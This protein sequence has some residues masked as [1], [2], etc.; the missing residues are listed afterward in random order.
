[1]FQPLQIETFNRRFLLVA[2]AVGLLLF[3][4]GRLLQAGG[5]Q[6]PSGISG[7]AAS[8]VQNR[9]KRVEAAQTLFT[10]ASKAY[11]DQSYAEAMDYY[12]AAF[13]TLPD[14]PAMAAQRQIFFSR[15]QS[16]AFR[17]AQTLADDGRWG[18]C[19]QTLDQ[20]VKLADESG[21]PATEVNPE[22]R[23]MLK[24]LREHDD[25][26]NQAISP[27]HI[28]DAAQ[29]N[30]KLII[31]K[32]YRELGDY[33]RAERT[34]NEV[35]RLDPY[36]TAA[37]R[38]M[39]EMEQ[40]RLD[41]YSAAYSHTRAK[42]VAEVAAGWETPIAPL[43]DEIGTDMVGAEVAVGKNVSIEKKLKEIMIPS[44]E[45]QGATLRDVVDYLGQKAQ[46][47]DSS[48]S[49]P[50]KRG[51]NFVIDTG[52]GA[53]DPASSVINIKLANIPLGVA[54]NYAVSQVGLTY[55]VEGV[56]VRILSPTAAASSNLSTR[57][58]REIPP[59]FLS[60]GGE[61]GGAEPTSPANPFDNSSKPEGGVLIKRVTA[62]QFLEG[63]GVK[64][65]AGAS[66]NFIAA[67]NTL[68]VQN[69]GEQLLLID[70][71][72]QSA[73][74]TVTKQVEI[75]IRIVSVGAEDLR[76]VGLDFLLG[77]SNMGSSAR[78]FFGGGVDGNGGL[79]T[80]SLDFP[81][82]GPGGKP[83]GTYPVTGALRTGDIGGGD[84]LDSVIMRNSP[85]PSTAKAPGIL[86][87]AGVFT[88][89]QF[90][91]VLRA[92]DQMKGTDMLTDTHIVVRPGVKAT[93]EQVREFIYPTEYDPPEIPNQFDGVSTG[94]VFPVTPATPTA[95]ETRKLGLT[96]E[97]EPTVA[98]DNKTVSLNVLTDVT[99]FSGFINYGT[100]ITS[101]SSLTGTTT[102]LT[103]NAILMPVFDVIRE[104]ANPV[105]WDGQTVAIGGFHGES[106]T[107]TEDKIPYL[108]D[109]PVLGRAFRSKTN[110]AKKK[111]LTIF[112]SVR[113]I[114]PG[115]NPINRTQEDELPPAVTTR[116]PV[117][118][119]E[120][121][122][123]P[124]PVVQAK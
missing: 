70:N 48:E 66:A 6:T 62:Q 118:R 124:P 50:V 107:A 35:L 61:A 83:V 82:V 99:D 24:E 51:V 20:I 111:A 13:E 9:Q 112:V 40:L 46:E 58:W 17:Y 23:K 122:S 115:G 73:R 44:L 78:A 69:T 81:F 88:D 103:E 3:P 106:I 15:Y 18:E 120:F 97:V 105:V 16:A 26:Y 94:G 49:D 4:S 108:G 8:E 77:Q 11:A 71:I 64:F 53:T 56:A 28:R 76:Q 84:S 63:R 59:G 89:P 30:T 12:K 38:G 95:F 57:V 47:L 33:D 117:P 25:R 67:T 72:V 74:E 19:E 5:V 10:S 86:S 91:M 22:V 119:S 116:A 90:Q 29:V 39:E 41:Y 34:Y 31:A 7:I 2:G 55:R 92:L 32:G 104:A 123:G 113:L 14:V 68:I 27:R 54:L 36:N 100:P 45:F 98:A 93:I 42:K 79:G 1:M 85:T 60:G 65:E 110:Q 75:H 101:G 87:V 52:G 102:V 21:I 80:N 96:L 37:R 109:L 114:D 121:A 43:L